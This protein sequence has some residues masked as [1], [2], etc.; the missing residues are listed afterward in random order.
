MNVLCTPPAFILS[1][2][3]T[4]EKFISQH[5]SVLTTFSSYS[6]LASFTLLSIYN[7]FDEISYFALRNALYNL[8]C[9]SIFNDRAALVLRDS[10][11]IIPQTFYFVN[12]FFE[13]FLK[14]FFKSALPCSRGIPPLKA[15]RILYRKAFCLST[16]FLKKVENFLYSEKPLFFC[17]QDTVDIGELLW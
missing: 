14:K 16:P 15:T 12:T 17:R 8:S 1:Q 13:S 7:S 9:C 11:T 6:F 4:L 10:L 3:Q 5:L 2:D